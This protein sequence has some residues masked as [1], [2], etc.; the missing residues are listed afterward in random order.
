M[1]TDPLWVPVW[2]QFV[3]PA[4]C[5]LKSIS[6]MSDSRLQRAGVTAVTPP[7]SSLRAPSFSWASTLQANQ[8]FK[9]GYISVNSL[10]C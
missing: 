4:D 2:L 9:T 8:I 7:P 6:R 10:M 1:L 3:L 5:S